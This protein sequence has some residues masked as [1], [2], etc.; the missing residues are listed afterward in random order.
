MWGSGKALFHGPLRRITRSFS[1]GC[2]R[3]RA[4]D[5]NVG[6]D[7]SPFAGQRCC[8]C[9]SHG[10]LGAD[11]DHHLP[12][13][14]CAAE[15]TVASSPRPGPAR[16][17]FGVGREWAAPSTR[18]LITAAWMVVW[19][20]CCCS[21]NGFRDTLPR[22]ALWAS[23]FTCIQRLLATPAFGPLGRQ[24]GGLPGQSGCERGD[25]P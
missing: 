11:G 10:G 2:H 15:E 13:G 3:D 22:S 12:A 24:P 17:K 20:P 16:M 18:F 23:C 21:A 6:E 25:S 8:C 14:L 1:S 7:P 4:H 9:D 19:A 5:V